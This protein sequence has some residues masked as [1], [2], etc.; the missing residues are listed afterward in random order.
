MTEAR[1]MLACPG[2]W[3]SIALRAGIAGSLGLRRRGAVVSLGEKPRLVQSV[4]WKC[5]ASL[6]FGALVAEDLQPRPKMGHSWSG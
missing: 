5:E 1:E 6:R 3:L 4:A 2:A